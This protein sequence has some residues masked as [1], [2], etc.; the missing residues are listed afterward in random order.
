MEKLFVPHYLALRLK[1]AGFNEPCFA[2][3]SAHKEDKNKFLWATSTLDHILEFQKKGNSF[4]DG[5]GKGS[6]TRKQDFIRNDFGLKTVTAPLWQQAVDWLRDNRNCH[7]TSSAAIVNE[8]GK[9]E[10]RWIVLI[11]IP[12]S[13]PPLYSFRTGDAPTLEKA[14]DT[15]LNY[16][17]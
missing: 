14:I 1:E 12:V 16:L 17:K 6:V 10:T 11:V 9:V 5:D 8:L 2:L 3:Y 7:I 4:F 13:H 15:A